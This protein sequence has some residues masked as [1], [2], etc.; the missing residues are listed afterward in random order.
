[1]ISPHRIPFIV[2]NVETRN[3]FSPKKLQIV[4]EL[5]FQ[6]SKPLGSVYALIEYICKMCANF[7]AEMKIKSKILKSCHEIINKCSVNAGDLIKNI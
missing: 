2:F 5:A 6:N 3:C 1:M 7:I 4:Y